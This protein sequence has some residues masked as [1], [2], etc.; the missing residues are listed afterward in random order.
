[1]DSW[2]VI[3]VGAGP[4]GLMAACAAAGRGRRTLLVEKNRA[5]G[6][7]ILLSGGTRC[8]LT[9]VTDRR[10]ICEAFGPQGRFLHSALA[11]LGPEDVVALLEAE[12]V[13]TKVEP[14]GKV[15]PETDRAADVLAALVARLRRSG[16]RTALGEP[17]ERIESSGSG[18]RLVTS[19]QTLQAANVVLATGGMSYPGVPAKRVGGST[20]DGYRWAAA[21]GHTIVQPR[22]ALVPITTHADWVRRL[23]GVTLPDVLLRVIEPR[24]GACLAERRGALLFAHFGVTGP[25]ALDAS[26]AVSGHPRPADLVLECDLAPDADLQAVEAAIR[27]T[28]RRAGRRLAGGLLDAWLPRRVSETIAEHAGVAAGRR[29]AELSRPERQALQSGLKR[30]Q[31]PVAGTMGFRKAEVTAGGVALEEVDSSTLQSKLVPGLYFAGE[32]LD[33]DG[34]IGG[35]NFQAAFSTGWLAGLSA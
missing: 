29:A 33:L 3:V 15:F 31:I 32:I 7:K 20:G 24:S 30:L 6:A 8:N 4:A 10:G 28:C 2:D 21:L 16:C 35:Y 5:A 34:P 12:G 11:A 25:A 23:Q 22:P 27:E 26:R 9:H 19:E 1:L 14:G 17:V 13:A 18:L